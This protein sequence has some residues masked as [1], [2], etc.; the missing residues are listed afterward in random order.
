MAKKKKKKG[1][2]KRH[3][4]YGNMPE[5]IKKDRI[6]AQVGSKEKAT[7]QKS[8]DLVFKKELKKNLIFVGIFFLLI[9]AIYFSITKT[10]LL[11]PLLQTIGLRNL[12]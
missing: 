4:K 7:V 1:E 3:L 12:Y 5:N 2:K 10:N 8:F 11:D 9:L 6:K